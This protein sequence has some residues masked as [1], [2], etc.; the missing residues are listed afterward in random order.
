MRAM[1][2]RRSTALLV[3]SLLL[4]A[5]LGACGFSTATNRVY[6]PAAGTNDRATGVDVLN[7]VIV[8]A[9]EGSG[10]LV[11]SF[12]NNSLDEEA[13]VESIAAEDQTGVQ[14]PDFQP[15]DVA[16]NGLVNLAQD[17]QGVAVEGEFAAG[18]V[19]PMVFEIT[20]GDL[21]E[22]NVPVLPNCDEYAGIDGA[23]GECEV[24]EPVG[25]H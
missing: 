14:V 21:V 13:T 16:P 4:T 6:T 22:L 20:G 23:G 25:E 11:A 3:G 15:I 7:A 12:V 5:P 10:T 18:D 9:D 19:V 8:S 24:S 2:L 1:H 17:D